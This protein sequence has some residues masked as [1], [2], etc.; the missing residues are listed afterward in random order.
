MNSCKEFR[1]FFQVE[2]KKIVHSWQRKELWQKQEGVLPWELI[3]IL[4][5]YYRT[6]IGK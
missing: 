3:K 2:R 1:H 4:L 5:N 6:L